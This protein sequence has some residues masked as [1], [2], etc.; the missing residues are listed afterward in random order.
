MPPLNKY[1][2][3]LKFHNRRTAVAYEAKDNTGSLFKNTRKEKDTHPDYSGSVR[4]DGR[5]LWIS[6]WLKDGKQG[7]FFSLSV[8]RKDGTAA[9]PDQAAEFKQ[10][11]KQAFPNADL[12]DEI[13]FAPEFR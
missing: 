10:A 8:K 5:D 13:P 3:N 9:R 11:V 12:S 7:K 4:I 6:A 2:A 1:T